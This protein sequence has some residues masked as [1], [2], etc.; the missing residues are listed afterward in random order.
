MSPWWLPGLRALSMGELEGRALVSLFCLETPSFSRDSIGFIISNP[1]GRDSGLEPHERD[2]GGKGS[3]HDKWPLGSDTWHLP[4]C[5]EGSYW[6]SPLSYHRKH[7]VQTEIGLIL[8]STYHP[9]DDTASWR[10]SMVVANGIIVHSSPA[11]PLPSLIG[12]SF[13]ISLRWLL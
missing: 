13:Y 11:A 8:N 12:L 4:F 9:V 10:S 2:A 3:S 1:M 7:T 6:Y 5:R